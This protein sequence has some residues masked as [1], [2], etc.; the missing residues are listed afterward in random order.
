MEAC[1]RTTG[2]GGARKSGENKDFF[3]LKR[4]ILMN[5]ERYFCPCRHQKNVELL[6]KVVFCWTLNSLRTVVNC[7]VLVDI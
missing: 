6:P 4:G 2:G 5:S 1:L 7:A 3:H